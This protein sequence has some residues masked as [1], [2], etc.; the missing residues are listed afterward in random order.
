MEEDESKWGR[1]VYTPVHVIAP[2]HD[3][4]YERLATKDS[5]V[6]THR[7]LGTSRVPM[8]STLLDLGF[9]YCPAMRPIRT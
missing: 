4:G 3:A 1:N 7:K 9:A 8:R 6:M 2:A 5:Y